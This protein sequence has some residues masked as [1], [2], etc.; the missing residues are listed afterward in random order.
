MSQIDRRAGRFELA[1]RER[2]CHGPR[3]RISTMMTTDRLRVPG[4]MLPAAAE[5]SVEL[6][7]ARR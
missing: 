7:E 2:H 1:R 6:A 4:A 3:E 5:T